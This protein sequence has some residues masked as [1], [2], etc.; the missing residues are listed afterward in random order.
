[1][2]I[3][4]L[5][6]IILTLGSTNI[7]A[8]IFDNEQANSN[9]NWKQINTT[10]FRLIFPDKFSSKA[11]ELAKTLEI[12]L[13]QASQNLIRKPRKIDIIVQE[14][15]LEQNGFVQLAPRKSELYSTPSGIA[16]NQSWLD[17]LSLHETRH[18]AQFDNLT[19][20]IRKPFGEQIALALFAINLPSWY[21][22]GDAVLHETLFS[23]GGRGRLASWQMPIR[24]NIQSNLDFN[25]N[26]YV[27]GSYKDLV[28]SYYTIGYFMNSQIFQKNQDITAN[29]YSNMRGKLLRPFNFQLALKQYYGGNSNVIFKK[30]MEYL[31]KKWNVKTENKY[32][33]RLNFDDKYPTDYNLPQ[34]QN[35]IFYTLQRG[36]Q[37]VSRI[38]KIDKSNQN[39]TTEIIKT[40]AQLMPYFDMKNHLIVWDE[41]RRNLRFSKETFNAINIYDLEKKKKKTIIHKARYYTPTLSPDLKTIACVEVDEA[42]QSYLTLIDLL[43][44]KK[45][46][47]IALEENTH[48]QQP[49]YNANGNKIVAIGVSKKGTNLLEIDLENEQTTP[50][51]EWTNLQFERPYY[52]YDAVVF[53]TNIDDK[54]DIFI[55]KNSNIYRL[56]DT[57]FGAFNPSISQNT[58]YFNDYTTRGLTIN[59]IKIDSTFFIKTE[60]KPSQTLYSA[61][62]N[63]IKKDTTISNKTY[64]IKDYKTLNHAINFHSISLS[65]S[66]FES[67]DNL[68]PGIFFLST[69]VLNTTRTQ[70]GFEYDT[71]IKKTTYSAELTYQKY[72]PKF[73]LGFKNRGLIGAASINNNPDSILQFDYRE[74]LI[75]ADIQLPLVKYSGNNV[76]S[77]GL[78]FGTSYQH[79]Y[80]LSLSTL[81]NFNYDVAFP[82]NYQVYFNRNTRRSR[83]DIFPRWGQNFN[84]IYRHL[85]F[86]KQLNGSSWAFRTSFYFP[87][88]ALNHGL[89]L[90]Y[91]IQE[92]TGRFLHSNNIP[93]I[94]GIAYIPYKTIKNTL[95]IDYR[96][97]I[98]YPDWSIGQLSYLK[99]IYGGVSANYLNI[100]NSSITPQSISASLFFDFNL[101]K[102]NLPNFQFETK[103]SYITVKNATKSIFPEFSLSYN[104]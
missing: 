44:E 35:D 61:Q 98:S 9:I 37:R 16:D 92:N 89:Q 87:G 23:N 73:T 38:V 24:A 54:D 70:L 45:I 74:N 100:E 63:F 77:Y 103:C 94:S 68:K 17:N 71:N 7:K 55:L 31:T 11:S 12:Q 6:A 29:V 43:T 84:F 81:R 50:L 102:Y 96:L 59:N 28:P 58:L 82:L 53:K 41:Y 33:N 49:Q 67:F 8:Q 27:H 83:M 57:E 104:Y 51:T 60:L 14:N 21:Y 46:K 64:E 13:S 69:D 91:A 30:T 101:F 79:R 80:N 66:D 90:R 40:G 34:V 39:K 88:L 76:Y 19:G 1:M 25:F 3:Y 26:K 52:Y 95:M 2:K 56:T 75:T 20:K 93:L 85:P 62:N 15:T 47:S 4:I 78:N 86:E 65:G 32:P 97:P 22:E 5:T 10:N 36:P 48:I 99:R 72:Y 42:N 18:V